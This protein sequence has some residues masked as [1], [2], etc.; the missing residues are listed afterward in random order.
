M[1]NSMLNDLPVDAII[2]QLL[3]TW[4]KPPDTQVYI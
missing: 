2:N 4:D 1:D 3:A